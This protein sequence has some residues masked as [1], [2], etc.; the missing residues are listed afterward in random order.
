MPDAKR[1]WMVLGW[2]AA[3]AALGVSP[4]SGESATVVSAG[5]AHSCA[6]TS[7]GAVW[8]WGSNI[9][10]QLGV[11]A[12]TPSSTPVTVTGL[13][14][15]A[16]IDVAAG[17]SHSCA[18]TSS[19]GVWCWGTNWDGQLGDGT[20]TTRTSAVAVSGLASGVV[21]VTAGDYHTC[22]L[23]SAG[24][25][26][27][28][29]NNS[30]GQLGDGTSTSHNTPTPVSGLGGDV[31]AIDAGGSFTCAVTS[32]GAVF[33]WGYNFYGQ[34]GDGTTTLRYTPTAVSGLS[35]GVV[36]VDAGAY[37][38]CAATSG[39]AAWCWGRNNFGQVGNGTITT[40]QPTPVAVSGLGSGVVQLA[41]GYYHTCAVTSVGAA[42]CWG[43][44]RDG[45][46]GDGTTAEYRSTPV[47]VSGLGSGV[48][49]IA[50]GEFHTAAVGTG[51]AI[52]S[53][54]ADGLGELADGAAIWRS[55]PTVVTGLAGGMLTT[56]AGA[57][58]SCALTSGGAALCW[59][60][61]VNG[62][63]GNNSYASSAT[64]V[65]VSGLGSGVVQVSAGNYHTCALTSAGA[66]WCWG[67]NWWG[68]L[69]DGT[70]YSQP[71]PVAV[72]GLA[73]DVVAIS[74][75]GEHTCA[76]TSGGALYC[77]GYN[78]AGQLGDGT[79]TN[80]STITPV[81]GLG[82]G[83]AGVSASFSFTCAVTGAGAAYCW[84]ENNN[85]QLGDGTYTDSLTPLAVSGL[86]TGT[87]AIETGGGHACAVTAGGAALCWGYN[88]YGQLG[89]GTTTTRLTP[90]SV[91]GLSS[92]VAQI[93]AGG[94]TCAVTSAGAALCWG[95]N[96][97]G[98]LGDGTTNRHYTPT[99]VS[100][101]G[102]GVA[103]ISAA[104][105]TC[106]VTT[107]GSV[108]CW[109]LNED[110][111]LG[112]GRP[113]D[114]RIPT[115]AVGFRPWPSDVNRDG[116]SDVVWRHATGGDLWV[117]PM[118]S[119]APL[120][121][122]Y[123]GTVADTGWQIK[124]LGDQTGDGKA[125]LL[126][127]HATSGGLLLWTMD[128]TTIT[129]QSY[130]GAVVPDYA[131]VGAAD[132]TGDGKTDILWR[133]Q[134]SGELWLWRM[135][136]ATL[137]AV[138]QVATI[139]PSFAVVA[140]GDVNGDGRADILWRHQTSGDV[141]VWLMNGAVATSQVYLGA[142]TDLGFQVAGLADHNRDG[143]ADV[144]WH[145][146]TSGDVW[147]WSMNGAAITDM[148]HVA[149]VGD[150]NFHVAGVGD[151]DGDGRADA[152]WHHATTGAVWVWLMNGGSITSVTQ[153]TTVPDV[154]YQI[155]NVK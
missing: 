39:G 135:N 148:S 108:A 155:V 144:L 68:Q 106:V 51:G 138:T 99:P 6:V 113:L 121:Q 25:V 35:S 19:G 44:N 43:F 52:W 118:S 63:L 74:A 66:V 145:H 78:F 89:D 1:W 128:G 115:P 42:Y 87:A 79:T 103:G 132:Y 105:H 57:H 154:G 129:A 142:V 119:G 141:W 5:Y 86:G 91:V 41:A 37:H 152:L 111:Q 70:T 17:H 20:S 90:T 28:W 97:Y 34:L 96:S 125:D 21:G 11:A 124:G 72:S 2:A 75:G 117:W 153:V 55:L 133:H 36:D 50:A 130:L 81:I 71:A 49:S 14:T 137:E 33:C 18:V 100:G 147:V 136:G 92:G 22:A 143:R 126:W 139:S 60:L 95:S 26:L 9:S 45:E 8:C 10:N 65:A 13:L 110:G 109:G 62:Q 61:N 46:V 67:A 114:R 64:P 88:S 32:G 15:R 4:A 59:G 122:T 31:V 134:T 112:D 146:A 82:S 56:S 151:Y 77:W 101:L 53:W 29:G 120:S 94:H 131:I 104:D 150:T 54:G 40:P 83:V 116:R 76:M 47:A 23:T 16:A 24:A 149:T 48:T 140:S 7:T 98:Q 84:G 73:G 12:M 123:L 27:C 127:R 107:T 69:G 102:S 30:N 3:A 80:R 93:S 38:A 85:G 58:H